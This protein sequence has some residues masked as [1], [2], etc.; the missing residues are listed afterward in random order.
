MA[1]DHSY[2]PLI[3]Q[4]V[5][6]IIVVLMDRTEPLGKYAQFVTHRFQEEKSRFSKTIDDLQI[7]QMDGRR[8][9]SLRDN[10]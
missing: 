4:I 1:S 10:V 8:N 6:K 3:I 9:F 2:T 7:I 5:R